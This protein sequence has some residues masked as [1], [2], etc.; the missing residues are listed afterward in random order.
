MQEAASH[1]VLVRRLAGILI[2]LN[3][4]E[5]LSPSDLAN[6]FGVNLRTIQR[7]L[8]DRLAALPIEKVNGKYRLNAAALGK[9]GAKDI[10]QFAVMAGVRDLF[11]SF[12]TDFMRSA[13]SASQS[14]AWLVKGMTL[15]DLGGKSHEFRA[16]EGAINACRLISFRYTKGVKS[17]VFDAVQPHQL[18]NHNGI[19]YL[20]ASH[21]DKV[22]TFSVGRLEGLLVGSETFVRESGTR[23]KLQAAQ[24]IWIGDGPKTEATLTISASAAPFFTRRPL[25]PHQEITQENSDG[26]L[27]VKCQ[28]SHPLEVIPVIK[29][30]MP[31][32]GISAPASLLEAVRRDVQAFLSSLSDSPLADQSD[33]LSRNHLLPTTT[34]NAEPQ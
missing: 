24:G 31:H 28:Y 13:L 5:A 30:W 18:V 26:S 7:D 29:Y 9:F 34:P 11:P 27:L 16:L 2:K 10:E 22:K 15:E 23:E 8:N 3:S 6:E 20:A 12:D 33:E 1:E 32:V 19:W 25:L 14:G 21:G 17:T 4:G